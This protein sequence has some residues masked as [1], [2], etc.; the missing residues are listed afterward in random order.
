MNPIP[1]A[2]QQAAA[3]LR[4]D[5]RRERIRSGLPDSYGPFEVS[6]GCW[7]LGFE[8]GSVLIVACGE[9]WQP[10]AVMQVREHPGFGHG[11]RPGQAGDLNCASCI[12]EDAAERLTEMIDGDPWKETR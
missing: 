9:G 10:N 4:E 1:T 5:A 2:A 8:D 7:K 11:L 6:G 12:R 3:R